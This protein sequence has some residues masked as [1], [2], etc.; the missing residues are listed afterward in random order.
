M[1]IEKLEKFNIQNVSL[2]ATIEENAA[3]EQ[4]CPFWPGP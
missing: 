2:N 1:L 4:E 3:V